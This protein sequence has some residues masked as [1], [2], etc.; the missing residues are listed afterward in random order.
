MYK[1]PKHSSHSFPHRITFILTNKSFIQTPFFNDHHSATNFHLYI[2]H[3]HQHG[4]AQEPRLR[5][6]RQHCRCPRPAEAGSRR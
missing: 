6:L 3:N 5:K 1:V 4:Q 2:N